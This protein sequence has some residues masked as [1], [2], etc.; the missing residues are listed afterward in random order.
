MLCLIPHK[1]AGGRCTPASRHAGRRWDGGHQQ[2]VRGAGTAAPVGSQCPC[3]RLMHVYS[4]IHAYIYTYI[5][6]HAYIYMHIYIHACTA[7]YMH[8]SQA[9]ALAAYRCLPAGGTCLASAPTSVAWPPEMSAWVSSATD[10]V[11]T[12]RRPGSVISTISLS[13]QLCSWKT[14]PLPSVAIS[15]GFSRLTAALGDSAQCTRG[16]LRK[17][18]HTTISGNPQQSDS[19]IGRPCPAWVCM[20]GL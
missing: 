12:A 5:Y 17:S 14:V 20:P 9:G 6:I 7:A 18:C 3:L 11:L 16:G 8:Q 2:S 4:S 19:G 10:V 1:Q 13:A 15:R